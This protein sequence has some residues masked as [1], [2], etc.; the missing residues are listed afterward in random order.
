MRSFGFWHFFCIYFGFI[1]H[2]FLVSDGCQLSRALHDL[3]TGGLSN[4]G[5]FQIDLEFS[6]YL[7]L[8]QISQIFFSTHL[9]IQYNTSFWD[10]LLRDKYIFFSSEEEERSSSM[11]YLAQIVMLFDLLLAVSRLKE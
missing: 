3:C 4:D 11:I 5:F 1:F 10:L 8:Y 7:Y 9:S 2:A 6:L